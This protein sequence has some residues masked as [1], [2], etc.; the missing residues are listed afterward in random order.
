MRLLSYVLLALTLSFASPLIPAALAQSPSWGDFAVSSAAVNYDLSG[1]GTTPGLAARITRDVTPN[2][3]LEVRGL[4]ARP[5]QQFGLSSLF[6]P[7]AQLQ[8]RW[9]V[10]RVSPYVGGGIGLAIVR[11][12][13][14]DETDPA[15]S[16]AAGARVR[17]TERV[18]LLGEM[19]LRGIEWGF[20]GSVAEWSAG[21][22][23]R[24]PSF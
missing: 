8:Y 11:S 21:L 5:D 2:V 10:G 12:A 6:I 4:Y 1:T 16:A 9:N 20:T 22:S 7:E 14:H 3:A 18:G 15:L 17:L 24:L 13:V 23:W 19:R